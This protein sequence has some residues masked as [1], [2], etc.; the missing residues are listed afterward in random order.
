MRPRVT[1]VVAV[2]EVGENGALAP[3]RLK[4]PE[5]DRQRGLRAVFGG[6]EGVLDH[7]ERVRDTHKALRHGW[8]G[9]PRKRLQLGEC[10]GDASRPEELPAGE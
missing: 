8:R 7:A 3:Q 5:V 4:G 6:K 10:D 1:S 2:V 9:R